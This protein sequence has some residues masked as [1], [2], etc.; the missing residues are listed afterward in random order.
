[1]PKKPKNL[2]RVHPAFAC[3][4]LAAPAMRRRLE[5]HRSS[6]SVPSSLLH[7]RQSIRQLVAAYR[8]SIV[9]QGWSGKGSHRTIT[10]IMNVREGSEGPTGQRRAP[11]VVVVAVPKS[12]GRVSIKVRGDDSGGKALCQPVAAGLPGGL[13]LRGAGGVGAP[14]VAAGRGRAIG[15]VGWGRSPRRSRKQG[16]GHASGR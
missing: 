1:M 13:R 7:T 9:R 10:T 4:E 5:A 6:F 14:G 11:E 8:C 16:P 2:W 15:W 12:E 3:C